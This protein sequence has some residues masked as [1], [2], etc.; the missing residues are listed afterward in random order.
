M[1][2][3]QIKH[4]PKTPSQECVLRNGFYIGSLSA[5]K[6]GQVFTASLIGN[7]MQGLAPAKTARCRTSIQQC[8]SLSQ[9]LTLE[10]VKK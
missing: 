7:G 9:N 1:D 2:A 6:R 8:Q 5:R 10:T 3:A 4:G